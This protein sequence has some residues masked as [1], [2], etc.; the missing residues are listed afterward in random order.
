M[1]PSQSV[2][3]ESGVR[4]YAH[5]AESPEEMRSPDIDLFAEGSLY[6]GRTHS[7]YANF[8][9]RKKSMGDKSTSVTQ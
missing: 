5:A 9:A 4:Y 6:H 2:Y 1:H 7:C 3:L 8:I